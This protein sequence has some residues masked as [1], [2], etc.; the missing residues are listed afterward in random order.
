MNFWEPEGYH[1]LGRDLCKDIEWDDVYAR[2][3]IATGVTNKSDLANCLEARGSWL[4]YCRRYQI[5]P[6][7]W[8][9]RL[10]FLKNEYTPQWVLRGTG[11]PKREGWELDSPRGQRL[12]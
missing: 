4:N 12:Q 2:F 10:V 11:K 3:K 6:V 8:L 7:V 5:V 9:R 1:Q